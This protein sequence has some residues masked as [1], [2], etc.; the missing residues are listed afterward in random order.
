MIFVSQKCSSAVSTF[1]SFPVRSS[2]VVGSGAM[3]GGPC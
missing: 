2:D 3:R 1:L